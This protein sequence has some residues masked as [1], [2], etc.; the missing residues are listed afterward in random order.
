MKSIRHIATATSLFAVLLVTG[1]SQQTDVAA[2]AKK[3]AAFEREGK[4]PAAM[5]E[6]KNILQGAPN[7][8]QARIGMGRIYLQLGDSKAAIEDL[9]KAL[10]VA[11]DDREAIALRFRADLLNQKFKEVLASLQSDSAQATKLG[12]ELHSLLLGHALLGLGRLDEA[13]DQASKA[14]G[15]NPSNLEA[16]LLLAKVDATAG[17]LDEAQ[18]KLTELLKRAPDNADVLMQQGELQLLRKQSKEALET[19]EKLAKTA[20]YRVQTQLGLANARL[21]ANDAKGAEAAAKQAGK[22]VPTSSAASYLYAYSIYRQ[23]R[24]DEA[25]TILYNLI[26]VYPGHPQCHLLTAEILLSKNQV[27]QAEDVLLPSVTRYPNYL[28]TTLLLAMV[29]LRQGDAENVIKRLTPL[30]A[31]GVRTPQVYSLL[32]NAYLQQKNF[33]DAS[34]MLDK[35]TDFID[36]PA[37][38]NLSRARAHL[39]V[40]KGSEAVRD[41][42]EALSADPEL[43]QA[44]ALLVVTLLKQGNTDK[45]L[46]TARRLVDSRPKEPQAHELLGRVLDATR[47]LP[48][49]RASYEKALALDPRYVPAALRLADLDDA[50]GNQAAVDARFNALLEQDL[51]P[52]DYAA[53]KLSQA[54]VLRRQK[55]PG[56]D[57]EALEA[58]LAKAPGNVDALM[59]LALIASDRKDFARVT[60]LLESARKLNPG[61]PRPRPLLARHYITLK[62]YASAMEVAREAYTIAPTN[63]DVLYTLGEA[64]RAV[65]KGEDALPMYQQAIAAGARDPEVF[66]GL[67]AAAGGVGQDRLARESVKRAL[68]SAREQLKSN[69]SEDKPTSWSLLALGRLELMNG[70]IAA[71]RKLAARLKEL[72]P[73]EFGGYDL[74][75]D[76]LM[77]ASTSNAAEAAANFEKALEKGADGNTVAKL[78]RLYVQKGGG[79]ARKLLSEWLDKHPDD[80]SLRNQLAAL[81]V[82][83]GDKPGAIRQLEKIIASEAGNAAALNNLAVLYDETGDGRALATAERANLLAPG[84]LWVADTYGWILMSRNSSEKGLTLLRQA[85]EGLKDEPTVQYHYAFALAKSGK[86]AE[87][88]KILERSLAL[89]KDFHEKPA[90]LRLA[91]DLQR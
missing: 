13:S 82:K 57:K 23:G 54:R 26:K 44:E 63:A 22:L 68:A 62:D 50:D 51:P 67:A 6:L 43:V 33:E 20:A 88:R 76:A 3:A 47:H 37:Q 14:L 83:S 65:G 79:D 77:A 81:L 73:D 69:M 58:A 4:L 89:N 61:D 52:A 66:F 53:V 70:D 80:L 72:A 7:D 29:Q 21:L 16:Q 15:E 36:N 27:H 45:A 71:A 5:I 19:F 55:G 74:D 2:L 40:G 31:A 49:A 75:G 25:L 78:A 39:A 28:P 85:A 59:G 42:E 38:A 46:E 24:A 11:P 48:E 84:D 41:L 30:A 87:A 91:L 86:R 10:S 17:R 1:C 35:A 64:Y 18:A 90:A 56:A 32:G 34:R 12:P 60:E 8:P 9:D